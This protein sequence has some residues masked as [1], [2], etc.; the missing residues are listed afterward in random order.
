M[1]FFIRNATMYNTERIHFGVKQCFNT[2]SSMGKSA[3][4]TK[5][6]FSNVKNCFHNT[7][8]THCYQAMANS[9]CRKIQQKIENGIFIHLIRV[10]ACCMFLSH[11]V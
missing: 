4:N 3:P 8:R 7:K 6:Y 11:C 2:S 5:R 9:M 1:R 10:N